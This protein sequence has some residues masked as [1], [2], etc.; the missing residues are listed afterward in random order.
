MA[1]EFQ[2][3]KPD[4]TWSMHKTIS[5]TMQAAGKQTDRRLKIYHLTKD[6]KKLRSGLRPWVLR[7]LRRELEGGKPGPTLRIWGDGRRLFAAREMV[8]A[9][10]IIDTNGNNKADKVWSWG[11]AK[12]PDC[13]FLGA[14]VCKRIVGSYT[15]SQH[16]YGNAV[17][18]GRDSMDE[19]YDLA[20]YLIGSSD[21]LNLQHVIVDDRIW[22]RGIGWG[23]Y[24][25]DRHYHVHAD[26]YQNMSGGCGVRN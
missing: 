8:P 1:R 26:F 11:K 22:N 7:G 25:G 24:G 20:Y 15:L 4:G 3:V 5:E 10:H 6:G 2:N 16:S 12:F 21:E 23:Y 17:D 18:F 14:Y 19:L 13:S 9:V